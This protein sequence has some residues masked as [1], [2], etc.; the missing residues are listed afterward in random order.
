[1]TEPSRV[2]CV[3]CGAINRLPAGQDAAMAK[4]GTCKEALFVGEPSDVSGD[5]FDRQIAKSTLPVVVDVWAPWC[6]PCL[7][8]APEYEKAA[9]ATEPRARFLKLNSDNEQDVSARLGIR[10]IPT[11]LL[12]RDGKE[13]ART[14]GSRSARDIV[15][16][17]E[18][19]IR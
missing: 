18:A 16:W 12:Y 6:G 3:A 9:Q 14:S 10:G 8:M 17:V 4:C 7:A 13:I 19:A 15:N 2:V 11:M 1:M 5:M